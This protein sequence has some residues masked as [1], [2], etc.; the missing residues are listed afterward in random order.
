MH[1][2]DRPRR[3]YREP[4]DRRLAGVCAGLA[5]YL[6]L[7]PTVVRVAAVVLAFTTGV[8]L[9]GYVIA[10]VV[11]PKRP[12][13]VPRVASPAPQWS[14][15]PLLIALIV[16]ALLAFGHLGWWF[17]GPTVALALV[18]VGVYLL[19][20]EPDDRP[21]WW[22]EVADTEATTGATTDSEKTAPNSTTA[23]ADDTTLLVDAGPVGAPPATAGDQS[24]D[25]QGEV[26]PPVP[27][28]GVG[29][30]EAGGSLDPPS[31]PVPPPLP[32]WAPTS[33]WTRPAPLDRRGDRRGGGALTLGVL[34]VLLIGGGVIV[35][36]RVLDI[37]DIGPE[38]AVA[39]GLLVVGGAMVV[40]A[41]QGHARPLL[42][43]GLPL[44][45]CLVVLDLVD[46][47]FDAGVG[48][49]TRI[50]DSRAELRHHYELTAGTLTLDLSDAPL[51]RGGRGSGPELSAEVGFGE[52]IVI[53]PPDVT[54]VVH[55][56]VGAGEIVGDP[57]G[58]NDGVDV[59]RTFRLP[60]P[61]GADRVD[62]D[63]KTGFG[64][65]E[66]RHG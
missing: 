49:R 62:L 27:P 33:T 36:L 61:E 18:A 50:V 31:P 66:V 9:I 63:L 58:P 45:A 43:L 17:N 16:I 53:V 47:P 54:A 51:D 14:G 42:A 40:G 65:V 2:A 5:D 37:A 13:S 52:L 35:L 59:R 12:P 60:G 25:P 32:R 41:W 6:G 10:A 39:A 29:S 28:W 22:P 15:A 30:P 8:G 44:L 56:K 38:R 11:V 19:L 3:L 1:Q 23:S 57:D 26:P 48:D 21:R 20:A 4:D 24:A 64:D 55:A 34:A 7:D 46:V